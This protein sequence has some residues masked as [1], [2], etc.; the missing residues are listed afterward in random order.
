V[1]EIQIT[2]RAHGHILTNTG[3]WSPDG[4]WLVYDTRSHPAGATFDGATIEIVNLQTREVREIYRARNGAHCGVAT[5]SPI[6]ERV[7][8]ILGPEDPTADWQYGPSHRQGVTVEI[9][10]PGLAV[11]FEARDLVPPFTAGALRGGSHVHVFSADGEWLSFTYDDCVVEGGQRNVGVSCLRQPVVVPKSHPR[12]HNG[13]AFS[14]LVT[15]TVSKP[16]RGSDEI[17]RAFEDAWVGSIG[18]VRHDGRRQYRAIAFQGQVTSDD[19]RTVSE[20]FIVDIPDD[21]M[22]GGEQPLAGTPTTLPAPPR[23]TVQRRLTYTAN[24]K[25]PGLQGPRY[26]L[27]SSADGSRIA[28][29]MRDDAGIVQLWTVSPLGG[30][31]EQITRNPFDVASAFS[32]SPDG[33]RIAYVADRSIFITDVAHGESLRVT[34]R[35]DERSAPRPEACVFSPD[36]M[37]IAYLRPITRDGATWNQ[38]FVVRLPGE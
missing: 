30:E 36:G 38:I 1:S 11:P 20:A 29:L 18:Y 37:G 9:A 28:L 23:G 14:V 32:W 2:N 13:D 21:V 3:V 25:Y 6:D 33:R 7:V 8:F 24:R 5:F 31:P 19:G 35:T 27:R 12:N 34:E 10:R 22:I 17:S 16:R 4:E 26:W 15:R